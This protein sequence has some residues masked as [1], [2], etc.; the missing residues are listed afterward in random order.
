MIKNSAFSISNNEDYNTC[1]LDIPKATPLKQQLLEII[2]RQS[3]EGGLRMRNSYEFD[4][5]SG[6]SEKFL[7]QEQSFMYKNEID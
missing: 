1:E 4:N 3:R 6:F 7:C 5:K 2:E